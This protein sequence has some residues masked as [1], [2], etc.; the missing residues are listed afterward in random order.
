MAEHARPEVRDRIRRWF[1][2]QQG[3]AALCVEKNPRNVLRVPFLRAVFPE[4]R[5]VHIVRDGR[6]VACSLMPGI[7]GERWRHVKP[8]SWQRLFVEHTGIVRCA[9][10]WKETLEIALE[11][12]SGVPH[13]QV[14]FEDLV[15]TPEDVARDVLA[16]VGLSP[17]PE[18]RGFY[19]K[20]ADVTEG[21]YQAERQVKWYRSDHTRR[22]GRWRE[23]M[24]VD[25]QRTLN[26]LLGP[27]LRRLGYPYD[28]GPL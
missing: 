17:T 8:P 14:R 21:S 18:V 24:T 4:A 10:A 26:Q 19:A 5:L 13:L 20:I 6:D 9:L 12:L 1:Q 3:S 15:D 25:E 16:Y 28:A 22:V 7:G 27:L 11:D 2:A 23:N